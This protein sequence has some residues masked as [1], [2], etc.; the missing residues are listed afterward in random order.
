M[1]NDD[2]V[3]NMVR[4]LPDL[5]K[6]AMVAII[7]YEIAISGALMKTMTA[8]DLKN[9]TGDVMRV[10]SRGEKV[11]VTLRGKPFALISPVTSDLLQE[12]AFRPFE[13]AWSDIEEALK[14]TMP[15]FKN[16]QEAMAW[17]RRK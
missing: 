11:V 13:Q 2:I 5:Q 17:T 14:K 1:T 6:S 3:V 9:K 4:M 8:K 12:N 15:K 10:V 7:T 16:A